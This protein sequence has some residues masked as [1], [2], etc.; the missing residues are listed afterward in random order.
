MPTTFTS[1][2]YTAWFV[3]LLAWLPGYFKQKNAGHV[4]IPAAQIATTALIAVAFFLLLS[5]RALG[6]LDVRPTAMNA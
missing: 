4:R 1:I 6:V 5:H 3:L 2:A